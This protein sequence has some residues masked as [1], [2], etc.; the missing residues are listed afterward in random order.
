MEAKGV[1]GDEKRRNVTFFYYYYYYLDVLII[2]LHAKLKLPP[3]V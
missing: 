2:Y 3:R 1:E